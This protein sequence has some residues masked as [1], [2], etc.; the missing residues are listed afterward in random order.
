MSFRQFTFT[1][2]STEARDVRAALRAAKIDFT[3]V[4]KPV[5]LE[6]ADALGGIEA[7]E[8]R[9]A[10]THPT[11]GRAFEIV[12]SGYEPCGAIE[13][14]NWVQPFVDAGEAEI[15]SAGSTGGGAR[16]YVQA[17][18]SGSEV[19][20]TPNDTIFASVNFATSH[21]GTLPACAGHSSVRVVCQ[22]TMAMMARSLLFRA[23]HR[24]N[25]RDLLEKGALEFRAQR[26]L[27]RKQGETFRAFAKRKLDDKQLVRFVR[28]T[29]APGAGDNADQVVRHVDAIVKAAH[30]APG[31]TPGTLWGGLNALTYWA[32]HERGNSDG[33]RVN[34]NMFGQGTALIGRAIEV[35]TVFAEH[36]PMNELAR[37]SYANHATAAAEFGALLGKGR[38]R[39]SESPSL[40]DAE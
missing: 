6:N 40:F 7:V 17:R 31:A 26:E 11:T 38:A 10:V 22:N 28:E 37:E 27:T 5:F 13:A 30:E 35:A 32:T 23:T 2:D 18:L 16:V 29:L 8:G 39:I 1:S 15:I 36:L 3:P 14:L 12:G 4:L 19:D 24:K 20:V 25:M 34:A 33:A 21:D 9:F